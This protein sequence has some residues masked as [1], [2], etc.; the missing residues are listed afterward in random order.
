MVICLVLIYFETWG[1]SW[2][3]QSLFIWTQNSISQKAERNQRSVWSFC[4]EK[5]PWNYRDFILP[6]YRVLRSNSWKK[7]WRSRLKFGPL[8]VTRVISQRPPTGTNGKFP[9]Y[10]HERS[11][12]PPPFLTL[13]SLFS[14]SGQNRGTRGFVPPTLRLRSMQVFVWS[15]L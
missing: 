12:W 11:T 10:K 14:F 2:N 9:R 3:L 1:A 8:C 4:L 13:S 15:A 5:A 6:R 7:K